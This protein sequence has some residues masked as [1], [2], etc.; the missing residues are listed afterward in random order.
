VAAP[1]VAAGSLLE[2]DLALEH[3]L[4]VH[5]AVAAMAATAMAMGSL[6][7]QDLAMEQDLTAGRCV[8]YGSVVMHVEEDEKVDAELETM[9]STMVALAADG[10]AVVWWRMCE[11][12]EACEEVRRRSTCTSRGRSS[13]MGVNSG[14]CE[15][16]CL[17]M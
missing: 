8:R 10:V 12:E 7:E 4:E 16:G 5:V 13:T 11:E 1:A 17:L 9:A 6:L 15:W 14:V 3:D 2:H